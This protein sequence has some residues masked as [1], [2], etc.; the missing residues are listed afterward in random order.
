MQIDDGYQ[1]RVGDWLSLKPAFKNRMAGLSDAI[2]A[3]GYKP[4]LWLAPFVAE[5]RSELAQIHPEYVLRTEFGKPI[6]AGYNMF[7]QS[8]LYYGLDI[9]N[10]RFEEYLRKVIRT[11][12]NT[13]GFEL[14]KCDFLFAG[15][16]RGGTHNDLALSRAE[17]LK[18]GMSIIREEAGPAAFIIGCGMP[19][20]AGIGLVDSMRVGTDTGPYWKEMGGK[21]LNTGAMVGVRNSIR[22]LMVRSAMH[23]RLWLN[24]PDCCMIRTERTR[25]NERERMSQINAIVLSGGPLL[26]SDDLERLDPERFDEMA[27]IERAERPLLRGLADGDRRHGGR[28]A[29][30]CSTTAPATSACSTRAIARRS[31]RWSF[32]AC[33]STAG[34]SSGSR[35][36]GAARRSSRGRRG[37]AAPH[38]RPLL[39]PVPPCCWLDRPLAATSGAGRR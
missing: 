34:A 4:G 2:R 10:I 33:P 21:V 5:R 11:V 39:A 3:A 9:T 30:R 27:K 38:A 17:V 14:L 8:H 36:S 35:T 6:T 18:R 22:N 26:F 23:K 31:A 28:A 19:L 37:G 32:R 25:L 24:D 15:C 1:T 13:W 20:S 16:L 29:R 12:T 7:W